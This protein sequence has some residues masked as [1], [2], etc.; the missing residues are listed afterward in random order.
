LAPAP[1]DALSGVSTRKALA[2][3]PVVQ[4]IGTP[5]ANLVHRND[6][7]SPDWEGQTRK[8]SAPSV[9]SDAQHPKKQKHVDYAAQPGQSNSTR[10]HS[11]T[12]SEV[13]AQ[14]KIDTS[15][16]GNPW[17][18]PAE[19]E[20]S[21]RAPSIPWPSCSAIFGQVSHLE[22]PDT[23]EERTIILTAIRDEEEREN[24]YFHD[25]GPTLAV[26]YASYRLTNRKLIIPCLNVD[27]G[28]AANKHEALFLP[29]DIHV[30]TLPRTGDDKFSEQ[31][32]DGNRFE[33]YY[34]AHSDNSSVQPT[35]RR[36]G[37]DLQIAYICIC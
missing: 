31:P 18:T 28:L 36:Y 5:V 26:S 6:K 23:L 19:I 15:L 8:R 14:A 10:Y 32:K 25:D 3:G 11:W 20:T 29:Y 12:D 17:A 9:I 34:H 16:S 4:D 33:C 13:C 22:K 37:V 2:T 21:R 35:V 1:S 30:P 7:D 27:F 24:R